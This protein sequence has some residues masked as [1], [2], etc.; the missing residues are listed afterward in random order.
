MREIIIGTRVKIYE[1][2]G[3]VITKQIIISIGILLY[4]HEKAK[5]ALEST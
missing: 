2:F 5:S 4:T 1:I 3:Q